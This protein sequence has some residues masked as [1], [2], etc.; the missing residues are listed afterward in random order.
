MAFILA[1]DEG[2]TSARAI[3]FDS[4]G[5]AVASSQKEIRLT[6]PG[7]GWVEQDAEEIWT[8]QRQ[9]A[10]DAISQAGLRPTDVAALG[11]TNQRETIVLWE[12]STGRPLAPAIVWQDRRTAAAC[13][14]LKAAGHEEMVRERS[15]LLLDPYFSA[16]KLAWLLE[17]TPGAL[18]RAQAGE[19]AAGTIDAWLLWK[20]TG[21]ELHATDATNASRTLLMNL[22]SGDWD[23]DLLRLFGIPR[24]LLP[25]IVGSSEAIAAAHTSSG[26]GGVRISGVAGDQQAA[27][28][29]QLCTRPG[30]TKS[31]YGTG[32]FVL[33]A[34]GQAPV[35]SR[36]RLLT[37]VA[38]RAGGTTHFALE[39]SIF[40]GGAVVQW[41]RDGL[42]IIKSSSQ[43][44]ALAATVPDSGG[45]CFVPALVGLGAP[46]WDPYARGTILGLT[47]DTRAGHLA[48]AAL[49]GVAFEVADLADALVA[50]SG[51][52]LTELRVDGGAAR[53]NMLMQFQADLL[54][55]PVVRPAF[56]ET[57]A[58]G[59]AYLAGLAAGVWN[60]T[61]E[62]ERQRSIDRRFEPEMVPQRAAELRARWRCAVDRAKGWARP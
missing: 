29:G 54:Q 34:T 23:E 46:H 50:D 18:R 20:L 52:P 31:T 27:L 28:F 58:L 40:I 41:L 62:L 21:G 35:P 42:G 11:I 61:D 60:S 43:I 12:R 53:N 2:T 39:G 57:T 48:R 7:E 15:G 17:N 8:L 32:C 19:L 49:E 25:R 38:S 59:A 24:E 55:A 36:H 30:M 10:L 33:Q 5:R 6:Y 4:A 1:L 14:R 9:V 37:T 56:I 44:E 47:R 22:R 45:V 51:R 26:L 3:I 16:T 13:E